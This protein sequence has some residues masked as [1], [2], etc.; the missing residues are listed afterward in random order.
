MIVE[1]V[2]PFGTILTKCI[3]EPGEIIAKYLQFDIPSQHMSIFGRLRAVV[4]L[5]SLLLISGT[6]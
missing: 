6:I 2:F 4:Y 3:T 5:V 1:Y